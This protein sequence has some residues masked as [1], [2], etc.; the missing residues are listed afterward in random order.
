MAFPLYW[1]GVSLVRQGLKSGTGLSTEAGVL[2]AFNPLVS[3]SWGE[4]ED[5]G[6]GP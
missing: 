1:S 5:P 3:D 4:L 2:L 6:E